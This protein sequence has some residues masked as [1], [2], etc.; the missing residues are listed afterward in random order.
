MI[1]RYI[2][3]NPDVEPPP[4]P[5]LSQDGVVAPLGAVGLACWLLAWHPYPFYL[6]GPW[7]MDQVT[8]LCLHCFCLDSFVIHSFFF[9]LFSLN[10]TQSLL[11]GSKVNIL[12]YVSSKDR[13]RIGTRK[14]TKEKVVFTKILTVVVIH[15]WKTDGRRMTG[16]WL[17]PCLN[18][19]CLN[20]DHG[21]G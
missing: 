3:S 21:V 10:H 5:F 18:G 11:S 20:I 6:C 13:G 14:M 15:F 2:L 7:P 4:S 12:V 17:Y 1:Q 16:V 19:R 8:W 9:P